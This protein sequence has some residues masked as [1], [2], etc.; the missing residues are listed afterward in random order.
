MVFWITAGALALVAAGIIA[1]AVRRQRGNSEHPA[2]YDLRVYRDQLKE[3]DKDLARGVI[4]E[5][6]ATRIRTE[7]SR[8][9]L[10]ADSQLK[11][12]QAGETT[13]SRGGMALIVAMGVVLIG[14]SFFGYWQLGAPGFQDQPLSLRVEEARARM[15]SRQSQAE[16][17]AQVPASPGPTPDADFVA[18][19]D[20]LRQTAAE[21]PDDLQGQELLARNEA[22]MGN[23]KAAYTAQQQIIRIKGD[24]ASSSDYSI[25]ANMMIAAADG[26]VSPEAQA[27]LRRAMEINPAN[28]LARYYWGLM[29]LQNDRPDLTFKI[30][31][32][33]LRQSPPDAP[34]VPA[35]R[36]R[37]MDLAWFAGVEY[38]MPAAPHSGDGL[39]GPS[40]DDMEAASEMSAEDRQEMIRGMVSN[41]AER[42]ATEG[43]TPEEWARLISAYGVL[44]DS[45]R[46]L[47][48]WEEAKGVFAENPEALAIV[49]AGA[50]RA[51][52][53]D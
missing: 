3:V 1:L 5:A 24:R 31:D 14:L 9:I 13:K 26:Y 30:W 21:R 53:A 50:E 17:E 18:L 35:I 7:V 15:D 2:E 34:W 43:G 41:L 33:V 49:R 6:D 4:D 11:A 46:A 27:A 45:E 8:R 20:K 28:N 23:F 16:A 48:I 37:I 12:E 19:M 10:A 52:V 36:S 40:S 32:Q 39:S 47:V 42:L 44:G 38:Q 22:S 51:G 29:L 25:L